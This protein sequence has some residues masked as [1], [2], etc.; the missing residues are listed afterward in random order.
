V[1]SLFNGV[2]ARG[3]ILTVS[4]FHDTSGSTLIMCTQTALP[5][6][7]GRPR[8]LSMT[9]GS[10][11]IALRHS[12]DNQNSAYL[13]CLV[14]FTDFTIAL[15]FPGAVNIAGGGLVGTD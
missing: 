4:R 13:S 1:R 10:L 3:D 7:S 14:F 6:L 15:L 9:L 2:A 12:D 5:L 11:P 8:Q